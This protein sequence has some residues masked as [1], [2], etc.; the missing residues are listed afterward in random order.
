MPIKARCGPAG[1]IPEGGSKVVKIKD[2]AIALFPKAQSPRLAL[3]AMDSR[4]RDQAVAVPRL[5]ALFQAGE[6]ASREDDPW[7]TYDT[8]PAD[9]LPAL[10]EQMLQVTTGIAR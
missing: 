8:L 3:V 10:W 2:R 7:W 5:R 1:E 6:G 9:N 4:T